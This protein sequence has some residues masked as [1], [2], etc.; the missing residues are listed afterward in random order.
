MNDLISTFQ[1]FRWVDN[2]V[3]KMVSNVHMRAKDESVMKQTKKPRVNEFN[4]KYILLVWGDEHI[5]AVKIPQIINSC[6]QWMLGVNLVDQLIAYYRSRVCC[7]RTWMPLL[8]HSADIIRV[9]SY[10]LYK[11]IAYLHPA[12]NNDDINY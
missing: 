9:N 12:V 3:V 8:L 11:E 2:N 7:C 6:N 1:I 10:N 5:V 4:R